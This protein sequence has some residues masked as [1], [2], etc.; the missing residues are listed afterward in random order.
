MGA[1]AAR[2]GVLAGILTLSLSLPFD[3]AAASERPDPA[4]IADAMRSVVSVLPQWAGR[5]PSLEEPE[6]SGVVVGDGTMVLTADHV[7][8][9]PVAVLVRTSAGE[10]LR[11]DIARRDRATDLA[12]LV[13][14]GELPALAFGDPVLPGEE[15]CA[16]GNAFGLGLAV[17]CG[18]VSAIER[19]GTGFNPVE[20]F[21]QIDAAVNPGMSG[22]ALIDGNGRLAGVLSAIFTKQSDANI[23]VNFAVSAALAEAAFGRFMSTEPVAWPQLGATLRAHPPRGE[24]GPVGAEVAAIEPGS[25]AESA[26]LKPGDIVVEGGGRPIDVPD[27]VAAALALTP[28]GGTLPLTVLRGGE[29]LTLD[30]PVAE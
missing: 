21:I 5:P 19:S 6:G 17:A 22:G 29:R 4:V 8:G 12:L 27:D 2:S 10:V 13:V 7:L 24:P 26:G 30:V 1:A 11:A 3:A 28:P 23:G 25:L 14:E 9:D 18:T 16:I 20:D 15:V